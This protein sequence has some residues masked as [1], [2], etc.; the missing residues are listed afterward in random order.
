MTRT[1]RHALQSPARAWRRYRARC[2]L[3]C[4]PE[5]WWQQFEHDFR[6]YLEPSASRARFME[7]QR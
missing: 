1:L 4:V 5:N 2:A 7:G 6:A 3:R